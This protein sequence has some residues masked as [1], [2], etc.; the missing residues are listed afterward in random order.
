MASRTILAR[1]SKS[2][3]RDSKRSGARRIA[4]AASLGFRV[5]GLLCISGFGFRGLVALAVL[6]PVLAAGGCGS[7]TGYSNASLFPDDVESVYLEMFDNR[8]FRRGTEFTFS[9][10]LAKQ[11]E[12]QTPYKIV[13]NR[14]RADSVMGGQLVSINESILTLERDLGRALEKEVVLT[15]VVNW[16]SL[17]TGRLMINN[18]TVTAAASYSEF[19]GQDFTYASAVAA[20][21]LAQKVVQLMEN[22]W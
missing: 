11:I 5:S 10:A 9:N 14:D 1:D 12:V 8:S 2:E 17:K 13:S 16:K 18:Q 22:P 6:C 15:V 7:S 20:N 21:K 3:S 19:Q 4:P